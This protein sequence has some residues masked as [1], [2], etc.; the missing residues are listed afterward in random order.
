MT[1]QT[2][3]D[4]HLEFS[5]IAVSRIVPECVSA[6]HDWRVTETLAVH[7]SHNAVGARVTFDSHEGVLVASCD[8][9]AIPS[10]HF[11]VRITSPR[12]CWDPVYLDLYT[13]SSN[14][15]YTTEDVAAKA[16]EIVDEWLIGGLSKG[17]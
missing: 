17:D 12:F 16:N 8:G 14:R 7:M 5:V 11:L 6:N 1:T 9:V 10:M 13:D 15:G 3:P 2:N 4:E